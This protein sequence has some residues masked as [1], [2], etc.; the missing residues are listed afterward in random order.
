M[1]RSLVSVTLYKCTKACSD[2]LW[3]SDYLSEQ[4]GVQIF[5]S[6][7]LYSVQKNVQIFVSVTLYTCKCRKGCSGL[8]WTLHYLS[9]QKDVHIICECHFN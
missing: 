3:V 1:F 8:L 5:V 7:T 6:V 4:K 2:L 9:L